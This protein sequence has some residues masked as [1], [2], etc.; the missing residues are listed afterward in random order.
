MSNWIP[1]IEVQSAKGTRE[2]QLLTEHLK[3]RRVFLTGK[4]DEEVSENI[5]SQ[6]LYL[7]GKNSPIY[8]II[9]SPGGSISECL[10]IYD[11][12]Q[13]LRSQI[14]MYCIGLAGSMA[15]VLLASGE[16]GHRHILPHARTIIREPRVLNGGVGFSVSMS[17][18][19]RAME[20]NRHILY[21]ILARHTER[22]SKEIE[23]AIAGEQYMDAEES[24]AFGLCDD[25][26]THIGS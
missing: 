23:D 26:I 3:E 6:L 16:K 24:I 13:G 25:I 19:S 15:A 18:A 8:L 9:N 7:D 12:I 4:I 20:K 11:V 14:E 22:T 21:R 2:V 17:N 1:A 5:V 10:T